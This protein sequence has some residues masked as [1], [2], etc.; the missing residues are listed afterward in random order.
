MTVPLQLWLEYG[1]EGCLDADDDAD[2][3]EQNMRRHPL[4]PLCPISR[5]RCLTPSSIPSPFLQPG[6]FH[7][8]QVSIVARPFSKR[9]RR[10]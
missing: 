10:R 7:P 5:S 6:P 9:I 1:D 4:L 2:A 8:F 3:N